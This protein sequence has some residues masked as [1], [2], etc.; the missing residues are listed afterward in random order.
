MLNKS[1]EKVLRCAIGKCG[2]NLNKRILISSTDFK[3]SIFTNSFINSICEELFRKEYIQLLDID[4]NG[5]YGPSFY[6]NHEGFSYFDNKKYENKLLWLK[7]AWIPI[8]VAFVTTLLTNY[9]IPKLPYLIKLLFGF[10]SKS[11]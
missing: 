1:A 10:L 11:L 3:S 7:N 6:L 4:Y 9:I 5:K 2:N 8:I